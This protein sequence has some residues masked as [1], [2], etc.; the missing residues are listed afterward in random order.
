MSDASIALRRRLRYTNNG[1]NALY[2]NLSGDSLTPLTGFAAFACNTTGSN[3]TAS[4]V[5]NALS[6]NTIGLNNVACRISAHFNEYHRQQQHRCGPWQPVRTSPPVITISILVTRVSLASP[7][8][9]HIG[10]VGVQNRTF[11]AG[12]SGVT[13]PA[14]VEVILRNRRKA[15]HGRFRGAIQGRALSRWTRR[16]K[17]STRWKPVT[18]R[19]KQEF[20]P[21]GIA[22]FGLVAEEVAK[23]N[24]DLVARDDQGK[25]YTV[26]YEAVNAMLLNEFTQRTSQFGAGAINRGSSYPRRGLAEGN[27][28]LTA[29]LREQ[30]AKSGR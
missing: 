17:R 2:G 22:Q 24:P 30:A 21:E 16:A 13:V 1:A 12:I 8:K 11:I 14:G 15:R 18:F 7:N 19:Y 25:P 29:R 9:I 6:S 5:I 10:T 4:T 23:V 27:S 28:A 20:D 3:N 26:R